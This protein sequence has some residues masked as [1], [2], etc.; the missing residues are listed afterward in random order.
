MFTVDVIICVACRR[1]CLKHSRAL[2]WNFKFVSD[3]IESV[4]SMRHFGFSE[5]LLHDFTTQTRED[6]PGRRETERARERGKEGG[7]DR[8]SERRCEVGGKRQRE[9]RKSHPRR[10]V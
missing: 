7:K 2:D 9:A 8:A 6:G 5:E 3:L 1:P 4:A 10:K